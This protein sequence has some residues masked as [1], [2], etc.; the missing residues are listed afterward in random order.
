MNLRLNFSSSVNYVSHFS[1]LLVF[2]LRFFYFWRRFTSVRLSAWLH[3]AFY[4]ACSLDV[5]SA[6]VLHFFSSGT[7]RE[8]LLYHDLLY[9][10]AASLWLI[11][12]IYR[13]IFRSEAELRVRN[14]I[15]RVFRFG[16]HSRALFTLVWIMGKG[17]HQHKNLEGDLPQFPY[18]CV[19]IR[20]PLKLLNQSIC[21]TLQKFPCISSWALALWEQHRNHIGL[22]LGPLPGWSCVCFININKFQILSWLTMQ[23]IIKRIKQDILY[24]KSECRNCLAFIIQF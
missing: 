11:R 21:F 17:P 1:L 3:P 23:H 4:Y 16:L 9:L 2:Q 12:L 7:G 18:R 22:K 5:E 6:W 20:H 15:A 14:Q 8:T 19:N 24:V 10:L 13:L